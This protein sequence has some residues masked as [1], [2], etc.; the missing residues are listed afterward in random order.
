MNPTI[1]G[2]TT[3]FLLPDATT[4]TR[5]DMIAT[6]STYGETAEARS[7]LARHILS[8]DRTR[9]P[10]RCAIRFRD[11]SAESFARYEGGFAR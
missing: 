10:A 3:R 9:S 11:P 5:F 6:M 1:A 7:R 2:K 8:V 4:A